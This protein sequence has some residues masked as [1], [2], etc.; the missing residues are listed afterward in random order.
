M[1]MKNVIGL[2]AGIGLVS[3]ALGRIYGWFIPEGGI[4]TA[5]FSTLPLDL[6]LGINVKQQVLSG[7]DTSLAG[8]LLA[9]LG[10][11]EINVM[12]GLIMAIIAG[13]VVAFVGNF[14]VKAL[15]GSNIPLPTGKGSI[16]KITAIMVYGTIISG[17][18]VGFIDKPI[19]IPAVGFVIALVIYYLIVGWMYGLVQRNLLKQLPAPE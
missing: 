11:G 13:I 8:R 5:T 19:N 9:M 17:V 10:G 15:K 1:V 12:A 18:I 16:G 4:A 3:W 6:P 7:V 2:G 14:V